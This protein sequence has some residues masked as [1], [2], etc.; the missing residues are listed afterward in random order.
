MHIFQI[1]PRRAGALIKE[2]DEYQASLYPAESNHLDSLETLCRSNVYMVGV[3]QS[4]AKENDRVI[5]IGAVKM[6]KNYGEIKRVY[7]PDEHRGKGLAKMIMSALEKK[8]IDQSINKARLETGIHQQGAIGLYRKLG[9]KQC[10][11]FGAYLSD[12]LS[13]FMSKRLAE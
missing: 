6:F 3:T 10:A 13:I 1:D 11:P 2:L 9:Y 4:W 8:L 12:P 5:A 7:V